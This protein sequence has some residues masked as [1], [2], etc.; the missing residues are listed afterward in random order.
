MVEVILCLDRVNLIFVMIHRTG[1]CRW[2]SWQ[3]ELIK[4]RI[5]LSSTKRGCA[6]GESFNYF[7]KMSSIMLEV[8]LCLDRVNLIF[9]MIHRTGP[10]RWK[11]WQN[12]LIKRRILILLCNLSSTKRLIFNFLPSTRSLVKITNLQI[13][14]I[15]TVSYLQYDGCICH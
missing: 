3:N 6:R 13:F 14:V 15:F 1:P 11:S 4:R 7:F 12:E 10:C 2:K 9:V 8:I 5:N